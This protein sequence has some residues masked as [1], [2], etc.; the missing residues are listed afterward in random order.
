MP[1]PS[2]DD[3]RAQLDRLLTSR[4]FRGAKLRRLLGFLVEEWRRDGGAK[5]TLRYIA[6]SL[7][8]EPLTFEEDSDKWGYPK[9]RANLG[10]V[11]NRLRGHYESEGY[12]DRVIIKLNPG[13]YTPSIA[14][15]PVS[16]GVADLDPAVARLILRAKTAID[17]RTLRGAWKALHYY[18]QIPLNLENPRQIANSIFIPMAA[19]PM[20]P[21]SVTAVQALVEPA[22]AHIKQSGSEPWESIFAE[23]CSQV[24]FKH[25]WQKAL[26]MFEVAIAVSQGEASYF[27]WYTALL[28]SQGQMQQAIQILDAAVRHFSRTN[29]TAR[30]DLALLQIMAG[31]FD[32]AEENLSA[33]LDLVP[34]DHPLLA[35]HFALF[36][37]AQDRME[38]AGRTLIKFF[39]N[40]NTPGLDSLP[41]GEAL[42]LKDWH[43]FLN[44]MLALVAGRAGATDIASE[45]V[46]IL[47]ACKTKRPATSS[48]ELALGLIGVG[49][50]DSAV[51]WLNAAAFEENDPFAMWFHILPPFRHLYRH[52]GYRALLR[53]LHLPLHR[54]G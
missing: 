52:K 47:L 29:V 28:A 16:T 23:A 9:T 51:E 53:K 42:E 3:V 36:Y 39:G 32:E 12:R 31:R 40:R 5:L 37:E 34:M 45:M 22:L 10:H 33:S 54:R 41:I 35:C 4:R 8:D 14:Y 19:A 2:P 43:L 44:G 6:E 11:R 27:W 30:T 24:C 17:L 50:F 13:S 48:V 15:N 25:Q 38:D 20:I 18:T 49:R 26:D 21:S 7:K 46:E 1:A